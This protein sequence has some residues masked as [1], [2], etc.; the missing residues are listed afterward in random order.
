MAYSNLLIGELLA[1]ECSKDDFENLKFAKKH[2]LDAFELYKM[3]DS[4]L[5]ADEHA[6]VCMTLS[7]LFR[8]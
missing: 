3:K 6:R 5:T 4:V 8:K 1:L 2:L 7:T